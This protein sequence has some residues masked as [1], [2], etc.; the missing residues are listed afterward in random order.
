MTTLFLTL[1]SFVKYVAPPNIEKKEWD[2]LDSELKSQLAPLYRVISTASANEIP[3]LGDQLTLQLRNF[4][5]LHGDFF[6]DEAAKNPSKVYVNH[7]NKTI[8]QLEALKR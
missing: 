1:L 7:Q 3:A 4:L 8:T 5:V 6:E 2:R